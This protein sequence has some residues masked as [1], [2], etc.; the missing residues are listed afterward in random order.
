VVEVVEE[1]TLLHLEEMV[2]PEDLEAEVV[3]TD[4]QLVLVDLELLIKVLLVEL[5]Q[6]DLDNKVVVAVAALMPL[7]QV[8]LVQQEELVEQVIHLL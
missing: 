1:T 6:M 7:V 5:G 8:V 4:L 3:E 2:E